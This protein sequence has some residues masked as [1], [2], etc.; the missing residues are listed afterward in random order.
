[1]NTIL[2]QCK[3]VTK[4][5][6]RNG[7]NL[8]VLRDVNLQIKSG[9]T[10][11]IFGRSGQ[12]KS[13]LLSLLCGLDNPTIGDIIFNGSSL[14][15]YSSKEI[16]KL[17]RTSIGIIFQNLNL[18]SSWTALENVE[19]ALEGIVDSSIE[20]HRD[21]R[22]MLEQVGLK[23]RFNH[24]PTEMSMGEQQRVAIARTLVRKPALILADEPTGDLDQESADDIAHLLHSFVEENNTALIV[25]THGHY[26]EHNFGQTLLLQYGSINEMPVK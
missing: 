4:T 11:L 7:N 17:R 13:V 6:L 23:D 21:A 5:F 12:G 2:L 16:S 26:P 10:V 18:I 20:R 1:M 24:F 25:A 22:E 19:A 14:S 3:N 15:S 8:E 9:N